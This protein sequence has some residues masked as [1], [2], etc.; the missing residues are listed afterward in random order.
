S[1]GNVTFEGFMQQLLE[2]NVNSNEDEENTACERLVTVLDILRRFE[3]SPAMCLVLTQRGDSV[4]LTT[5]LLD[6]ALVG[7]E[8]FQNVQGGILMSGT[9]TPPEMYGD[10]LGIPS[11]REIITS[12]YESPFM[13]D[14]RPVFIASDVSTQWARRGEENTNAIRNHLHSLLQ[15]TPGHVAAFFPSYAMLNEII[16]GGYWPG[17]ML[18]VEESN[19]SK[20]RVET[21]I[22]EMRNMR[23]NGTKALLAGVYG[24]RL[25]EGIDYSGNLLDAVACVGIPNPPKSV[26]NDALKE[27]IEKESGSNTAWR[28]AVLQPAVNR[29]LQAMGRAI[30]K[31][32]DRAF[33]LLLDDRLLKPNYKRCLPPTFKP[34]TASDP[35]RTARQAKRFF[36]RHPEPAVDES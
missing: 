13:A 6:P 15:N 7:K 25:S 33:V 35:N 24:G 34:F 32:E 5:H 2:V 10:T 16:D 23:L 21:E 36:E 22:Q 28:Y 12:D 8:I 19:W 3:K 26:H 17:R 31:A 18:S 27:Y 29:I 4:S 20:K 30:R 1:G 14:R 11:S 9:L